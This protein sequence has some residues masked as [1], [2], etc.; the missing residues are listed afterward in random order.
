MIIILQ[1]I[2]G[3]NDDDSNIPVSEI[4]ETP[5]STYTSYTVPSDA[6]T[7]MKIK[8]SN[9]TTTFDIGTGST[10][11]FIEEDTDTSARNIPSSGEVFPLKRKVNTFWRI[12]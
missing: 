10:A 11:S 12:R 7:S 3:S 6:D 2:T 9:G 8:T 1:V 4:S 5:V